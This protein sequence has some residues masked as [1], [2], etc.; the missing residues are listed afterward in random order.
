MDAA[1]DK[2][3]PDTNLPKA[4]DPVTFAVSVLT[5]DVDGV[6]ADWNGY[7]HKGN[8]VYPLK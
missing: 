6:V 1:E 3:K 8:K 4:L 5:V 7:D 2:T